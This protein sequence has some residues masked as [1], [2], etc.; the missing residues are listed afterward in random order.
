MPGGNRKQSLGADSA[1]AA[2]QGGVNTAADTQVSSP[3]P[4]NNTSICI[5]SPQ[6]ACRCSIVWLLPLQSVLEAL[7]VHLGGENGKLEL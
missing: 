3:L 5:L 7:L 4:L 6:E 1:G 2:S